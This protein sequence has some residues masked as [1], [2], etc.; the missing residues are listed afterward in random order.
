M[1]EKEEESKDLSMEQSLM[2]SANRLDYLHLTYVGKIGVEPF[3]VSGFW[4]L[5]STLGRLNHLEKYKLLVFP[6]SF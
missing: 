6:S 4:F 3:L 1:E 5:V 2:D